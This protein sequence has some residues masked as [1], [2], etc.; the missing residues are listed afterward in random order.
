MLYRASGWYVSIK[1]ESTI[2]RALDGSTY[3]GWKLVPSSIRKKLC[4]SRK[5]TSYTWDSLWHQVGDKYL[6]LFPLCC[7]I[8]LSALQHYP[9]RACFVRLIRAKCTDFRNKLECLS[10]A[11]LSSLVEC[12]RVRTEP[13]RVKHFSGAPL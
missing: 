10:L 12:L 5:A 1:R 4:L 6:F 8:I 7:L 9:H 2:N 11:S 13:T 3:S